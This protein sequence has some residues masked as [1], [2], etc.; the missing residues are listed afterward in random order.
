MLWL[1]VY[2]DC[3]CGH[4]V[5]G[6]Y[7]WDQTSIQSN[8]EYEQSNS[9]LLPVLKYSPVMNKKPVLSTQSL[10]KRR[11]IDSNVSTF[12]TMPDPVPPF[13][14]QIIPNPDL[15]LT[16]AHYEGLY[17]AAAFVTMNIIRFSNDTIYTI[18]IETQRNTAWTESNTAVPLATADIT[19]HHIIFFLENIY[20]VAIFNVAVH[21]FLHVLGFGGPVWSTLLHTDTNLYFTGNLTT[22]LAGTYVTV[23]KNSRTHWS[24]S[25]ILSVD[26]THDIME[27]YLY[28]NTKISVPS[29]SV[30]EQ[31]NPRWLSLA[32]NTHSDCVYLFAHN[33]LPNLENALF[34]HH[35]A[36][37]LPGICTEL[38]YCYTHQCITK[39]TKTTTMKKDHRL[40]AIVCALF[41]VICICVVRDIIQTK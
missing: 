21:E 12:F 19:N 24:E 6:Y 40:L 9:V 7:G 3:V 41:Y 26:D 16:V 33:N 8:L 22:I 18:S 20:G 17:N 31:V 37:D 29:L 2:Y 34:C 5:Y 28:S 4:T 14:L 27:P 10:R 38:S 35:Y 23:D 25:S 11:T 15:P 32:C 39:F 36:L 30:I 1:G 13:H